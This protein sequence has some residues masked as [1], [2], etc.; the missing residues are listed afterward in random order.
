MGL[1]RIQQTKQMKFFGHQKRYSTND[2]VVF[3]SGT[4]STFEKKVMAARA[5]RDQC[6]EAFLKAASDEE[7]RNFITAFFDLVELLTY[8]AT[9]SERLFI[10]IDNNVLQDILKRDGE[11]EAR[12]RTRYHALLAV[13]AVAEDHFILDIFACVTPAV[14]YEAAYRGSRRIPELQAEVVDAIAQLGLM[15]HFVGVNSTEE[16]GGLFKAIRCDELAIRAALDKIK[17]Q[18]WAR[19]FAGTLPGGTL[20]PL[21]VAERECPQ[22]S[23][24]YFDP[25]YVKFL[26]MHDIEKRM[27]AEN[28]NQKKARRFMTNPQEKAFSVLKTKDDGVEGLGDIELMT[29]CD[30]G[31]QTLGRAPHITFG[32]TFDDGLRKAL[33]R[34]ATVRSQVSVRGGVDNA[35]E[36]ASRISYFFADSARRT[37]KAERRRKEYVEAAQKAFRFIRDAIG[38]PKDAGASGSV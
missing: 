8:Y 18:S 31:S 27:F 9:V 28:S 4:E 38:L 11:R 17:S 23:L 3:A 34:R 14:L 15:T 7:K 20:I 2:A 5:G 1:G 26:L 30:L 19:N 13:L 25:W 33:Q 37:N 24:S 29:Y 21:G 32:L 16:L 22:V 35:R 6:V 36:G 10:F 12:R